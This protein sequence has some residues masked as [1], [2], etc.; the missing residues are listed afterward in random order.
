MGSRDQAKRRLHPAKFRGAKVFSKLDLRW[1]F[2]NVRIKEGDQWKAAFKTN[3]GSFEPNVMFFGL[4]NS[5][6]SFQTMMNEILKDLI[7]KNLV[8][9]YMDDIMIYTKTIAEHREVMK[10]VLKRLQDNNL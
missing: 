6:A 7:N 9:V 5:P 4:L 1:G 8:V 2:N 3:R 10:E